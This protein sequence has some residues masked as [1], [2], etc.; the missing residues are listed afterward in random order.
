MTS[1]LVQFLF[2]F[3]IIRWDKGLVAFEWLASKVTTFLFFTD[4]GTR[5]VFG[6]MYTRHPFAMQVNK[7][8]RSQFASTAT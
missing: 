5:F 3:L 7:K 8:V 1:L 6:D 2:G 4:H